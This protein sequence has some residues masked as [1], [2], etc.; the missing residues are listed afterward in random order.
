VLASRETK[1][2]NEVKPAESPGSAKII[3][4]I[5]WKGKKKSFLLEREYSYST[6]G[7]IYSIHTVNT[8]Y[9]AN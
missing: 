7:K 4:N 5:R 2:P 6:N 3:Q 1:T 8:I 9:L